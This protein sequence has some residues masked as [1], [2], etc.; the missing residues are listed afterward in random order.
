[1]LF[2]AAALL[3]DPASPG[4]ID[5]MYWALLA[6]HGVGEDTGNNTLLARDIEKDLRGQRKLIEN[7][8]ASL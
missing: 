3:P 6:Y 8:T 7:N 2:A 4:G 5:W 1:M